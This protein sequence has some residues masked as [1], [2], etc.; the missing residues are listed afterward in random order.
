MAAARATGLADRQPT[1]PSGRT[2]V[3]PTD[4]LARSFDKTVVAGL[5]LARLKRELGLLVRSRTPPRPSSG[6][7]LGEFDGLRPSN[8]PRS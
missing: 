8:S 6:H 2:R 5:G 7:H 4:Y 3:A 1:M